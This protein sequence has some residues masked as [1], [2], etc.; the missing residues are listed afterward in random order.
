MEHKRILIDTSV[1][2]D[3]FRRKRKDK[4]LFFELAQ[5]YDCL[6]S[7]ITKFEFSVG[8]TSQNREYT[9][10][11]LALLP[12]L[13]FDSASVRSA[14]DIYRTLKAR[15]QLISLP[16]IFIAAT[17]IANDLPFQTLNRKHFERIDNLK[18]DIKKR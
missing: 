3:H 2:I 4:T 16:D 15:N 7:S 11:L 17:A 18:L 5:N 13:P 6:I 14:V 9:E 8:S 10:K 1:L 12:A